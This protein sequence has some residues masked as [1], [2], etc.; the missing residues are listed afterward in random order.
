MVNNQN[1]SKQSLIFA[2]YNLAEIIGIDQTEF[3]HS[4]Y[5]CLQRRVFGT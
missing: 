4:A 2:F 3:C 5:N 1:F